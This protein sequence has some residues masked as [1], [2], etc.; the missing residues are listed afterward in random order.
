MTTK[1]APKPTTAQEAENVRVKQGTENA[2][3]PVGATVTDKDNAHVRAADG[4]TIEVNAEA[5]N[6][7]QTLEDE[8][9]FSPP[10][11]GTT[12]MLREHEQR[13]ANGPSPAAVAAAEQARQNDVL[14]AED[15][16]TRKLE[17]EQGRGK[18]DPK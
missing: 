9:K 17:R 3:K 13:M 18:K 5:Q 8:K 2:P 15:E 7:T 1:P 11:G 14:P 12:S 4:S 6:T 10:V 16:Y